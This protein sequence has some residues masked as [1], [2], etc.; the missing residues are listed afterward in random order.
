MHRGQYTTRTRPLRS[1]A[2]PNAHAMRRPAAG[3]AAP[4]SSA[5]C[6]N[7]VRTCARCCCRGVKVIVSWVILP[8]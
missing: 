5:P 6:W 2:G 7:R 1:R 8:E 3:A 4:A